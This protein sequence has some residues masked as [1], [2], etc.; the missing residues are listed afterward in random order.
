MARFSH[1]LLEQ[2]TGQVVSILQHI[3][4]REAS[5][6]LPMKDARHSYTIGGFIAQTNTADFALLLQVE[7]G[8]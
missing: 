1:T 6:E 2:P 3:N 7:K 4:A 8:G 5:G